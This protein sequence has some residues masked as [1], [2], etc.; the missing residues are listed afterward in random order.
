MYAI[1][2]NVCVLYLFN[3]LTE[4]FRILTHD[5]NNANVSLSSFII[6]SV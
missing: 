2:F 5:L 3:L 1:T 6:S 4:S